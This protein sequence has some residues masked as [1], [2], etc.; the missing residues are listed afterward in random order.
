MS[1]GM[2]SV[3]MGGGVVHVNVHV[4][5][6]SFLSIVI[7][8]SIDTGSVFIL[9]FANSAILAH[10]QVSVTSLSLPMQC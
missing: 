3:C 2:L 9:E 5:M 4:R 10:Q 6:V 8:C 7:L 1:L